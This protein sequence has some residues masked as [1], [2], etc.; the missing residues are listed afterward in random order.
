MKP[1]DRRQFAAVARAVTA[2]ERAAALAVVLGRLGRWREVVLPSDHVWMAPVHVLVGATTHAR[3][4]S[5]RLVVG[6]T[7]GRLILEAGA[8]WEERT[9][10]LRDLA[11]LFRRL[12]LEWRGIVLELTF[13][14]R[15]APTH[16]PR[17]CHG[18]ALIARTPDGTVLCDDQRTVWLTPDGRIGDPIHPFR[19]GPLG[20]FALD[21]LARTLAHH[22]PPV[23][24]PVRRAVE[25]DGRDEDWLVFGDW[26]QARGDPLGVAVIHDEIDPL[27]SASPLLAV[28][29]ACPRADLLRYGLEWTRG[30]LQAAR[31]EDA[32]GPPLAPLARAVLDSPEGALLRELSVSSFQVAAEA[33]AGVIA[34]RPRRGLWQLSLRCPGLL[35]DGVMALLAACP[36]LRELEL[37]P[38]LIGFDRF[39]HPTLEALALGPLD[40]QV[41]RAFVELPALEALD[42]EAEDRLPAVAQLLAG[43]P[44]LRRL[45]LRNARL[46]AE[47]LGALIPALARLERLHLFRCAL[48][49]PVGL[50]D[51]R[52]EGVELWISV[53][54]GEVPAALRA[55][56]GPSLRFEPPDPELLWIG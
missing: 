4:R 5:D 48:V 36:A 15:P 28:W 37:H 11:V 29:L 35:G 16:A 38:S 44:A 22:P 21:L 27:Q 26:L 2:E 23:D 51:P 1:R 8:A 32:S 42:L 49:D 40:P 56:S 25:A 3:V 52:L 20:R 54:E 55:R 12:R 46:D 10:G 14:G 31:I 43:A 33:I 34:G 39:A 6:L 19:G 41:Q 13:D 53:D 30:H 7:Q 45:T 9:G 17:D 24:H 47:G 18:M 50:L